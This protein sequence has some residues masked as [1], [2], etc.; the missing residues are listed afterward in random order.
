MFELAGDVAL[1]T[2]AGQN[3]G[4]AVALGLAEAGARVAVA[5]GTNRENAESVVAEIRAQGRQ[6]IP[7][8]ADISVPANAKKIVAEV[9]EKLGPP[10]ILVNNAAIRPRREFLQITY[11][12]W[13]E[14]IRT[15]LASV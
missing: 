1:V 11:E 8:V 12:E 6:A 14:V 5:V 7:I 15:N 9:T 2:G 4:R 13:D 3:I 10:L